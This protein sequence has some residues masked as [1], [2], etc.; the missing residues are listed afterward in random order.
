MPRAAPKLDIAEIW[1]QHSIH[2]PSRTVLISGEINEVTKRTVLLAKKLIDADDVT[3]TVELD[4]EGGDLYQ[5]LAIYDALRAFKGRVEIVG[6]GKVMSM[7]TVILQAADSGGRLLMPN[8]T[9]L[10][11]MGTSEVLRDHA[12]QVQRQVKED[13]RIRNRTIK[14]VTDAMKITQKQYNERYSFDVYMDAQ[15]AVS[16]G[17]ADK[18]LNFS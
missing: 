5:G 13:K 17:L 10:E 2:I 1:L 14:I 6:Y 4:T 8:T 12:E 16:V 7:G 9:I 18:V 15:R 11:H 3:V